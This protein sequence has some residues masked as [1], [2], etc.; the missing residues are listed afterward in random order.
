MYSLKGLH[1]SS[2]A[3]VIAGAQTWMD[4]QLSSFF[5]SGVQKLE[6][7]AKKCI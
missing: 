4:G 1:F 2:G 5:L 6:K 7:R 3:E